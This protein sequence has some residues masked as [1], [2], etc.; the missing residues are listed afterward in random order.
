MI[1]NSIEA[2]DEAKRRLA[3]Q[4]FQDTML[5]VQE[6]AQEKTSLFGDIEKGG[7][8][9]LGTIVGVQ[10]F[11]KK[12]KDLK[13]K[14]QKQNKTDS[15]ENEDEENDP[16]KEVD[17]EELGEET[18]I[19]DIPDIPDFPSGGA[20]SALS[21]ALNAG[22][23]SMTQNGRGL[24]DN[25]I[26][27]GPD[28]L[29]ESQQGIEMTDLRPQ[30]QE[31]IEMGPEDLQSNFGGATVTTRET[32]PFLKRPGEG[33]GGPEDGPDGPGLNAVDE[34]TEIGESVSDLTDTA[35]ATSSTTAGTTEAG[36]DI[37]GDIV[38]ETAGEI[39]GDIAGDVALEAAGTALDATG[40][41]AILGVVLQGIGIAGAAG[42]VGAGIIGTEE[43]QK[44]E[45]TQSTAAEKLEQAEER[46]PTAVAGRIA[47]P[48]SSALQ[49]IS[50]T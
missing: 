16:D 21:N 11:G 26:K 50:S 9:A 40:V 19:P 17:A 44:E 8:T 46:A 1:G 5:E 47:A 4:Q 10:A 43:A 12:L 18:E 49:Q 24:L 31:M 3:Q 20:Q 32:A 29:D 30:E 22:E 27:S 36:A 41:G 7:G 6:E 28:S 25:L 14:F 33:A 2:L 34:D 39:G 42:S 15:N 35:E 13:N 23:S 37:A 48:V 45:Q 38:G